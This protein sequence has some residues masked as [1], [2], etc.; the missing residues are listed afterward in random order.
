MSTKHISTNTEKPKN[1]VSQRIQYSTKTN[2]EMMH[3]NTVTN[4][5]HTL[6]VVFYVLF[7][8][9]QIVRPFNIFSHDIGARHRKKAL[10][11]LVQH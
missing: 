7:S 6:G 8:K 2:L 3:K 11:A 9:Q 10:L 1:P 4:E 5:L